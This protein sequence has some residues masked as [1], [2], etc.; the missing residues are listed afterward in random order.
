MELKD[1]EDYYDAGV[2]TEWTR[3]DRRPFEF[4]LTK[5]HI[6]S[7]LKPDSSIA[8]VG[9]GPGRYALELAQIGHRLTLVDLSQK[10]LD[11][12]AQEAQSRQVSFEKCL[13]ASATD[14]HELKDQAYDMVLCL[15][16]LY[17]ITDA[18]DRKR[19]LLECLRIL[20]DDGIIIVAF[21]SPFSHAISLFLNDRLEHIRDL[22]DD[23]RYI[24]SEHR[25]RNPANVHF[26][27]AWY[28]PPAS[29]PETMESYGIQTLRI[30]SVES[31]GWAMEKQLP[32]LSADARRDW[33]DYLWEISADPSIIGAAQ[34]VL[35]CGRKR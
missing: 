6:R 19:A 15:G 2:Q 3:M 20:K 33:M 31:L 7:F 10:S 18:A 1:I 4:E 9:S 14:L 8:D 35:F 16:P 21:L 23:F 17:H 25:N 28:P 11:R 27:H 12:A 5:R 30:A 34:H 32:D 26:T 13:H 22:K 29:I 24:L